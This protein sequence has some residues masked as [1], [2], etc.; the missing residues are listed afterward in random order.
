[1]GFSAVGSL[2]S[3]SLLG[4]WGALALRWVSFLA[5]FFVSEIQADQ[6]RSQDESL[7]QALSRTVIRLEQVSYNN[8]E[9]SEIRQPMGTGFFV[10]YEQAL[11]L[12]TVRHLAARGMVLRVR[13]PAQSNSGQTIDLIE[14]R[15]PAKSWVVHPSEQT[16]LSN[17]ARNRQTPAV[18]NPVDVAAARLPWPQAYQL[19]PLRFCPADCPNGP[20]QL[21]DSDPEPP[22]GILVFGYPRYLGVELMVQRPLARVGIV[23]MAA[24]EPFIRYSVGNSYADARMLVVDVRAFGGNSGS[25][26]FRKD[27]FTSR[28]TLLGIISG[29]ENSLD[30]SFAEPVSRIKET[31]EWAHTQ[32]PSAEAK[33]IPPQKKATERGRTKLSY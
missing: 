21:A 28:R 9:Q 8:A 11:Y 22:E 2:F 4:K 31:I 19:A 14:L 26:V 7:Y 6:L 3:D 17:N 5:A 16:A 15:V 24:S 13:V 27:R 33:W 1:M 10:Q 25:P 20:N 30:L 29:G 18:V 32:N 23:A 12:V